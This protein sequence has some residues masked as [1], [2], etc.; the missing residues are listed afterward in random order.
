[1]FIYKKFIFKFF[2]LFVGG[3]A[4]MFI[5]KHK[6]KEKGFFLLKILFKWFVL[7]LKII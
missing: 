2:Y 6:P 4:I 3:Q 1:M 5:K 7:V